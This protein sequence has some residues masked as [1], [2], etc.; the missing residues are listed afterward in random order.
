MF[1]LEVYGCLCE[2]KKFV[3]NGIEAR[4][5]DFGYKGDVEPEN[6]EPYG[7]GNM[8]FLPK[9]PSEDVLKKYNITEAEYEEICGELASKLSFGCC[10]WCV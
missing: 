2:T 9:K 3:V 7:C 1:E 5:E 8:L 4:H 10:G 6:A